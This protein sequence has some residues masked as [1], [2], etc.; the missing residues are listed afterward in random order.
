MTL[1]APWKIPAA[2]TPAMAR[3]KMNTGELGAEAQRV[4]PT[5]IS[6]AGQS[7]ILHICVVGLPSNIATDTK[8]TILT[9]KNLNKLPK[10]GCKA[11]TVSK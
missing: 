6:T 10:I 4:E 1:R 2:P 11:V 7:L 5:L 8:Y 3:P 9:L